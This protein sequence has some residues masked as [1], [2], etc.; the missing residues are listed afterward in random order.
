[1]GLLTILKPGAVETPQPEVKPQ[2]SQNGDGLSIRPRSPA[3]KCGITESLLREIVR[4]EIR[5]ALQ[6]RH[7]Q[8]AQTQ[9][10]VQKLLGR[11]HI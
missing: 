2:S 1:M 10:W 5:A 7:L 3:V 6:E 11:F 9:S 8:E 4:D